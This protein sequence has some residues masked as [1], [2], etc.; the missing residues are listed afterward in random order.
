MVFIIIVVTVGLAIEMIGMQHSALRAK[1]DEM[2]ELIFT[3]I[4]TEHC[5]IKL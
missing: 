2:F 4:N 5:P 1:K 3:P